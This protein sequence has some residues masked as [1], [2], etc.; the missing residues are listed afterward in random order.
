ME[1]KTC[2]LVVEDNP[3]DQTLL[4]NMLEK[5]GLSDD[6]DIVGSGE[7]A[8]TYLA[9]HEAELHRLVAI[10]LDLN[11]PT[12]SGIKLLQGIRQIDRLKYLPVAVMTS[13]NAPADLTQCRKLGVTCY[14]SK[15]ITLSSFSAAIAN[16]FHPL[17]D[18][19]KLPRTSAP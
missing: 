11:L 17:D 16:T 5:A 19:G 14:V 8:L 12:M 4:R 2:I 1:M 9:D 18:T 6:V 7:D 13:S 3:D 10:F 15:P